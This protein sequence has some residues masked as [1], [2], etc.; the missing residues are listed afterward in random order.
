M[1]SRRFDWPV[2]RQLG[3]RADAWWSERSSR[4]R[5]LIALLLATFLVALLVVTVIAPLRT[6][7]M[8]SLGEIRSAAVLEA[9]LRAGGPGGPALLRRGD[10]Q[11]IVNETLAQAG[12][13]AQSVAPEGSGIRVVMANVPFTRMA[14]WIAELEQTSRLRVVHA[15]IDRTAS[16]GHVTAAV[17]VR[18]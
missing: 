7:R 13:A 15:Q 4:E 16:P 3:D 12:I 5:I 11:T 9:R 1:N 8:E 17:L 6:A 14:S 18:A 10:A 2:T